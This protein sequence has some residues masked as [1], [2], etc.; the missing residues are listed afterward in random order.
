MN[1][2]DEL[3]QTLPEEPVLVRNIVIGVHWTLVCSKYGG[4]A[5]TLTNCG[6]HGHSHLREVGN[7]H[8]KTAQELAQWIKSDNL[9]EASIGMAAINS[10]LDVDESKLREINASE[11]IA[12]KAANKN[13]VVVGHFPFVEKIKSVTNNCWVI[14]KNPYG[15]DFPEEASADY[16]PQADV[17]AI[18]GTS[19]IN[20]TIEP[21]LS[22]C[23]PQSI[24]IL[25]GPST[26]LAPVLFSH[27]ITYLSGSR[28][29]DEEA[30][31]LTVTQ[32]ASFPQVKGVRTVTL[33]ASE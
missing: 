33:S 7:L 10:L 8:Q 21:L 13:L 23:K 3:L 18:T 24:I 20:H 22:L 16:I 5:S 25:L 31:A 17:V 19:L 29:L 11:V 6:P 12:Q 15:D 27:G 32:G 28:I 9:L 4:L 2:Y 14:E 26:P 1:I 30:C